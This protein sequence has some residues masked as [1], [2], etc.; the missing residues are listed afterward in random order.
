MTVPQNPQFTPTSP[1]SNPGFEGQF[2]Y[3]SHSL[4]TALPKDGAW[5]GLPHNPEGYT[6]KLFWWRE[7]YFWNKEPEPD[8]TVTGERLDASAPPLIVSKATNAYADDIS[9]AMLVG[10][11]FPT[12]GCWRITGKY[13]DAEL[14]FVIWVAP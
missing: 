6:Q 9:S 8:L 3:G 7:G 2:W 1:Y 10:V 12:L 14:S 11:D 13:A 4:W 5:F